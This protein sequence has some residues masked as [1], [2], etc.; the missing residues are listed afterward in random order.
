MTDTDALTQLLK[1]QIATAVDSAVQQHVIDFIQ[2]MAMDP[3]WAAKI[4]TL[5]TH[6]VTQKFS[7]Q[8]SG[9]D[10]NTLMAGWIDDALARWKELL[11]ANFRSTGIEDRATATQLTLTDDVAVFNSPISA[12]GLLVD[13]DGDVQGTLSVDNLVVRGTVN[14]DAPAWQELAQDVTRRAVNQMTNQ[15]R[16]VLVQQVLDQ[17][18]ERGID[19]NSVLIQGFPLFVGDRLNPTITRT[20]ITKLGMLEDLGVAG[21][22]DVMDTLSVRAGRLGINTGEPDAALNLWDEEV[23]ISLGKYEKNMAI[24]GTS[25]KQSLALG[26]NR[27][28]VVRIDETG[29][30]TIPRLRLDRWMISHATQV[31]GYEG[32]RG[33]FVLN[34]DPKP[35]QPFAWV[36]LGGAR[37]Q[38][39]RAST[40]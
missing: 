10:L 29:L 1:Q 8:I 2:Q 18:R 7:D 35:D 34:S 31:P 4:E 32:T 27:N 33:D 20:S 15:W 23:S 40:T 13:N 17:A 37:W 12:T 9:V 3:E 5:V 24:I 11:M 19:F 36:C 26:I 39:L 30:T 14:G 21:K 25:R 16:E 22:M 6:N 38:S 28:P